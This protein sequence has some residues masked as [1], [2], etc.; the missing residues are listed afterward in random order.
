MSTIPRRNTT[1]GFYLSIASVAVLGWLILFIGMPL[2]GA[3]ILEL[4]PYL[5][6][7]TK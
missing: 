1:F 4:A 7:I 5:T 2:Y 6:P 3:M